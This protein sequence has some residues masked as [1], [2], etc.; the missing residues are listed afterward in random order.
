MQRII[1]LYIFFVVRH[2]NFDCGLN[3]NKEISSFSYELNKINDGAWKWFMDS[4]IVYLSENLCPI[5]G[6][7]NCNGLINIEEFLDKIHDEDLPIFLDS[8]FQIRN[9]TLQEASCEYRLKTNLRNDIWILCRIKLTRKSVAVG[10]HTD[11]SKYKNIEKALTYK[12]THD[13]LTDLYNK[14]FFLDNLKQIFTQY[15]ADRKPRFAVVF[16]DLD[17]YKVI[18][19]KYGHVFGDKYLQKIAERFKSCSRTEAMVARFGGD[20]FVMIL[21]NVENF[22]KLE[23]FL[24]RFIKCFKNSITIKNIKLNPSTSIGAAIVRKEFQNYKDILNEADVELYRLKN[25]NVS[26]HF[27]LKVW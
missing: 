2:C 10:V 17:R 9:R 8:V 13:G 27:S 15:K 20:E 16:A 12:A 4:N 3:E 18:N 11:I 14:M 26:N 23:K 5:I 6:F 21:E 7:K 22:N 19:D 25:A 24:K 1:V